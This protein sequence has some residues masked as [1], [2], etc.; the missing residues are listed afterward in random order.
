MPS[1]HCAISACDSGPCP[2]G[3]R[4]AV[5]LTK[6]R[7]AAL[8]READAPDSVTARRRTRPPRFQARRGRRADWRLNRQ[9]VRQTRTFRPFK[10]LNHTEDPEMR[11]AREPGAGEGRPGRFSPGA[12]TNCGNDDIRTN[13]SVAMLVERPSAAPSSSRAHAPPRAQ[14][15]PMPRSRPVAGAAHADAALTTRRGRSARRCR[16]RDRRERSAG[17]WRI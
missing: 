10:R 5:S 13:G 9:R 16:C 1:S 7:S 2:A 12:F 4:A 3:S 6:L 15:T 11:S 14:R 8:A 17:G